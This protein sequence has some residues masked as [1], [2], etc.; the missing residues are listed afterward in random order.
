MRGNITRRGKTSWRLKFDLGVDSA[1]G[2]RQT[3]FVT[4][5][6][7]RQDAEREL[8]KLVGAAH[9]GTLI[10]PSKVSVAEYLRSWLDGPHGLAGKT[11]ER[12]RQLAEQQII[13]H[14]GGTPLQE[15]RPAHIDEWHARLITSGGENGRPLGARTV[16]HAHRVLH[17]ALARAVSSEMLTR[18]VASV[19]KPPKVE[20]TEA[21]SLKAAEAGAVLAAVAGHPL[22]PIIALALAT[23]ARRGEL[24]ALQWGDIDLDAATIRIERSLE[25]TRTGLKFKPP[26]TRN[27]RRTVSLPQIAV[28]ALRAH[29]LRQLEMRIALGLGRPGPDALVFSDI[30]GSPMPPNNLSRDWRRLVK[31]ARLPDVPFHGLRH[32]HVSALIASKVDLLTISRRIG[33]ASPV[34]T[35]R[36]YAHMFEQ[37]DAGAAD[38]IEAALRTG[39]ER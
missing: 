29:R 11:I 24:L 5:R 30:N 8:A 26:K 3:R 7:R 37:T 12:Y 36:I 17:R 39:K 20:E 6:G 18:N 22:Q 2:K 13:P 15:L 10:E 32:S 4:V 25:Q 38:A 35:L 23:G 1:T 21:H 27:G 34:V 28:E 16:G 31:R 19:I 14:L 33:H 9:D